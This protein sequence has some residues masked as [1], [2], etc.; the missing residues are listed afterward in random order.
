MV[1]LP[2]NITMQPPANDQY[3]EDL[4]RLF[5]EGIST[6]S[7]TRDVEYQVENTV[8]EKH[9][10]IP[11]CKLGEYYVARPVVSTEVA[12]VVDTVVSV[13]TEKV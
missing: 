13:D 2:A 9:Y 6:K 7:E 8:I 11:L 10:H 4:R 5:S 1:L 3:H 12:K